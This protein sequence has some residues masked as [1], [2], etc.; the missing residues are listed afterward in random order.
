MIRSIVAVMG[1]LHDVAGDEARRMAAAPV[2][3]VPR[4]KAK[5]RFDSIFGDIIFKASPT[6][7]PLR[8]ENGT[9]STQLADVRIELGKGSGAY[10]KAT[11]KKLEHTTG[12]IEV[13]LQMPSAG[14]KFKQ[15]VITTED[16]DVAADYIQ[17]QA[18]VA[19]RY[20]EW[21][22]GNKG[23][24]ASVSSS[25]AALTVKAEDLE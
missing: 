4:V 10:L 21:R 22:K 2:A 5:N 11:V 14:G 13:K 18:S 17:W 3:G 15:P 24:R 12:V 25:A 20:M 7:D 9:V 1:L 23:A 16:A 19:G 6:R 8:Y